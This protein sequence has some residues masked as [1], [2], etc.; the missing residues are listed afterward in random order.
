MAGPFSNC[1]F[2]KLNTRNS[3]FKNRMR[4]LYFAIFCLYFAASCS[5]QKPDKINTL[6]L[7]KQH[8]LSIPDS[9]E[10]ARIILI[11]KKDRFFELVTATEMS[12]QMKQPLAAGQTRES[13]LPAF[14]TYL[15]RDMTSFSPAE[16]VQCAEVMQEVFR[17]C[18]SLAPGLF[19]DT[20]ILLKTKANHYGA[21]VYYT[22]ENTIII[23]ADVLDPAKRAEFTSTMF[24]EL[25][26]VFSR[27]NPQ[28][29]ASLYKLI[30]FETIGLGK[31]RMP[32]SLSGRVFYNPDGV[33][34]AQKIT[35]KTSEGKTIYAIPVIYSNQPGFVAGKTEFFGYLE[36]NLFQ[37]EKKR[38]GTWSVL[39][40]PDG[41]SSTLDLKTLPD[42]FK[43]I[44]DNTGY[45]I[46]PDEILADNFAFLLQGKSNP[47]ITARFSEDGK[48]LLA[49]VE[50]VLK[51]R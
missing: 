37:I 35:L 15:S 11:D 50:K 1:N 36:F 33:D 47:K 28:K 31:L 22:R 41:Y 46:H 32:E 38:R 26:H 14:K 4:T 10:A 43:Q 23:P 48:K 8:V 29:R 2:P 34:F 49:D 13:L 44:K 42:F 16:S 24:H 27:L 20:L 17:T 3:K 12:I 25:F 6:N 39:T 18:D 45:I 7:D 51:Q 19:P 40:K 21:S 5:G 9:A 30:G